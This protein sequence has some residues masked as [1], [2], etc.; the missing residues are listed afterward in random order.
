MDKKI[1]VEKHK[2]VAV[3]FIVDPDGWALFSGRCEEQGIPRSQ[4]IRRV[5]DRVNALRK[6]DFLTWT[7]PMRP[8]RNDQQAGSGGGQKTSTP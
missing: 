2:G 5:I 3:T 8:M 7:R 6:D 1:V 4:A